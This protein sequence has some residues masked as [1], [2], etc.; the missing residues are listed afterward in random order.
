M[1]IREVAVQKAKE[2]LLKHRDND[3]PVSVDEI[4][5]ALSDLRQLTE[6]GIA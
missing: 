4:E 3:K 6:S 1:A 2:G 5:H